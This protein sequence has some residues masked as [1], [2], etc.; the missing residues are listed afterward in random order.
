MGFEFVLEPQSFKQPK[1][2]AY[3]P[4]KA[5]KNYFLS[6]IA[7]SFWIHSKNGTQRCGPKELRTSSPLSPCKVENQAYLAAGFRLE[8]LHMTWHELTLS[9]R[10][11]VSLC[12]RSTRLLTHAG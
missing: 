12:A 10:V 7:V 1:V 9:Q 4:L 2:R 11:T 8:V 3:K 5:S 6:L